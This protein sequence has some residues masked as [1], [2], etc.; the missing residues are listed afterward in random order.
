[1]GGGTVFTTLAAGNLTGA[2]FESAAASNS[3][4]VA[5]G[6]GF[7]VYGTSDGRI[8][9]LAYD[10][11]TGQMSDGGTATVV[12]SVGAV[13]LQERTPVLGANGLAYFLG[14]DGYLSVRRSA[15][16]AEV[17]AAPLISGA[18]MTAQPALDTYRGPADAKDCRVP[19]GS[20]YVL[21]KVGSAGYLT[22]VLVD[23]QGL[24][25]TAPWPRF[26]RDNGNTGNLSTPLS[27]WSCP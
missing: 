19:L 21:S 12:S 7:M 24:D 8:Q 27:S 3:G 4:P 23:S 25:P 2:T 26:Q 14:D 6:S 10:S 13:S 17:W 16:L 15:D 1:M 9:R 22:A 20:L 5:I 18:S 11:A